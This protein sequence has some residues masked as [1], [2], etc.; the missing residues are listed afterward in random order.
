VKKGEVV[1][2]HGNEACAFGALAAGA[3]FFSGYPITPSSEI[4][5][6][7]S[8]ELPKIGGKFIQM[9]DEIAAIAA[10]LGASLSGRKSLTATSGPGVSLKLENIGFA[11][12]AEIPLVIVSVMRGGPSTGL[13]TKASQ[14]DIMQARWGSH[15]DRPVIAYVPNSIPESFYA[16]IDA[17]NAAERYRL[18]VFVLLDEVLGHMRE[19][20]IPPDFADVVKE[21]VKRPNVIDPHDFLPYEHTEDDV[22]PHAD[23][24]D[25]YRYHVTGLFHDETGFPTNDPVEIDKK[26]RRLM[27]KVDR[28]VDKIVQYE[29]R[30][31]DDAEYLIIAYGSTSRAAAAAVDEMRAD[32]QKIG[33]LRPKTIWPFPEKRLREL[34]GQVKGILVPELNM[35]QVVLEVE[36]I[37][38]GR[39]KVRH[40]GRVD[41]ELLT[42]DEIRDGLQEVIE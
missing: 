37:C 36:R 38:A 14:A 29:E 1:L 8:E 5:E 26:M 2:W 35:G 41:G 16:T 9:E 10:A 3:K 6:I 42:P 22:P 7:L 21:T 4:A 34:A 40:L 18:P 33:L 11:A 27:R 24:G 30:C 28:N 13:P 25:N 32:G 23:F 19:R 31:V 39:T 17:F 12:M 15:G 20:F